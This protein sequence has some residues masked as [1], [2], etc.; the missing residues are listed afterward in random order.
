MT[1]N[2]EKQ[3]VMKELFG[4]H[5]HSFTKKVWINNNPE[6]KE[7]FFLPKWNPQEKREFWD[8]I[9][10][11]M[12]KKQKTDYILILRDIT[13]S[14]DEH[15]LLDIFWIVHTAKPEICWKALIKLLK[16]KDKG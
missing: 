11:A 12:D 6:Y 3:F 15:I 10:E 16:M 5:E 2:K 4:C 7:H 14:N 13:G 1:L 8:R 9:W